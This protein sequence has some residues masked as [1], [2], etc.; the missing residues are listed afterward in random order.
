[1][2]MVRREELK[3]YD[4]EQLENIILNI[5][6]V[7]ETFNINKVWTVMSLYVIIKNRLHK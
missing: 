2:S 4:R 5:F 1:M 6:A 7:I 3:K